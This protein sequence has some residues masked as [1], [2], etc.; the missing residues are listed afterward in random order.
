ML[1]EKQ[2][3][4]LQFD[5]YSN[6]HLI[7]VFEIYDFDMTLD[8]LV[9]FKSRQQMEEIL[10]QFD[11]V[12]EEPRGTL[13]NEDFEIYGNI[14]VYHTSGNRGKIHINTNTLQG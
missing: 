13:K 11:T 2:K 4:F 14:Y 6:K 7:E 9:H 1:N 8:M 10:R 12:K 5:K 3:M